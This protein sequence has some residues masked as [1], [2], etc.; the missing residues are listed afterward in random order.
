ML[1]G[2]Y[3]T[4]TPIIL[5]LTKLVSLFNPKLR[6]TLQEKKS[7]YKGWYFSE[8]VANP[9]I[10]IHV[11]SAGEYEGAK[12]LIDKLLK[13]GKVSIAV[14][15][16]SPSAEKGVSTT[17]G[18]YAYGFL[19]HDF[20]I[21]QLKLLDALNPK[22]IL[23]FKHDFWPNFLR[24]SS[25]L[26]IP[27]GLVN[28]NFHNRS[29]RGLPIIKQFHRAFMKNL[30]F[31]WTV[32]EADK[33]RIKPL[34]SPR[35]TLLVGGDSRYDRV[36]HR[37]SEGAL[38]FNSLSSAFGDVPIIIADSTWEP[39][40]KIVFQAFAILRKNHNNLRLIIAPHEPEIMAIQRINVLAEK[41][42]HRCK[43]YS[44]FD[45]DMIDEDVLIIDRTRILAD[46][47]SIAWAAYIGGGFGVGVHS[48]IE[49]AAC[50]LPV[51]F[52][53]N[54]HVSHEAGL[55]ISARGGFEIQDSNTV[56]E[57]CSSWL[58]DAHAY[59]FVSKAALNVVT[60]NLGAVDRL[61]KLVA[62]YLNLN[63]N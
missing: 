18:L 3:D 39:D 37:A 15:F 14:S 9:L 27:I 56:A 29:Q 38:K 61:L 41:Y 35:T 54:H 43:L 1:F 17:K 2:I 28:A 57:L 36:L 55:L 59:E 22:I 5:A 52:G 16:S 40:E 21:E 12:P 10:L 6:R 24:A 26:E 8:A 47:Y 51:M 32:S 53:P 58:S 23:I 50:A 20:I 30:D 13:T 48:V 49:P 7:G 62:P 60:S 19:P 46:L 4:I 44:D 33:D 25:R 31:I 45:G 63:S 11:A 34:V 42:L